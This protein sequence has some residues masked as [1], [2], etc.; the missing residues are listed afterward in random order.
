[1][2]LSPQSKPL[3]ASYRR[4][5]GAGAA[6]PHLYRKYED[7]IAV[8]LSIMH[9]K[10]RTGSVTSIRHI[11]M[12]SRMQMLSNFL[13]SPKTLFLFLRQMLKKP[14]LFF[15][16]TECPSINGHTSVISNLVSQLLDLLRQ[17]LSN[18]LYRSYLQKEIG[19]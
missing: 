2:A 18:A 13:S 8:V 11:S 10:T 14:A 3:M 7:S 1:M 19:F 17:L 5:R 16:E 15:L 12:D 4:E 9:L 6:I